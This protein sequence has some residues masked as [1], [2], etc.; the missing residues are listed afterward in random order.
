VA[1]CVTAASGLAGSDFMKTGWTAM[2]LG[3]VKYIIPF[4]FAYNAALL[5]HGRWW[6][7]VV[8]TFFSSMGVA[9]LGSALEGYLWGVGILKNLPLRA[10][11]LIGGLLM[12]F[13]AISTNLIGLIVTL[14]VVVIG[15][16]AA[17]KKTRLKSGPGATL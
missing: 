3:A 8:H 5:T 14:A 15:R 2:R 10:L 7:V 11:L 13:P 16:L 17:T 4:F 12:A 1:F 9:S 6:E